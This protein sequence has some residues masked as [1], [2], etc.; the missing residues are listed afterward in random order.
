MTDGI[1]EIPFKQKK[2][3]SEAIMP[4]FV[5]CTGII[6]LFLVFKIF[7]IGNQVG[8]INTKSLPTLVQTLDGRAIKVTPE[9]ADYR[10]PEL[11]SQALREWL[12]LTFNWSSRPNKEGTVEPGVNFNGY[13][14]PKNAWEA[15][16][17][18]DESLRS[19]FLEILGKINASVPANSDVT[20]QIGSLSFPELQANETG[21]WKV[22]L[23]GT[24]L[25]AEASK[26]E[27]GIEFNKIVTLEAVP[28][29]L[30]PLP[31]GSSPI[32]T[33]VYRMRGK[34]IKI[35]SMEDYL[36]K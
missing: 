21:V 11:L 18:L 7:S 16:F 36:A 5:L 27:R 34:G 1:Q 19:S 32:Q 24:L 10:E 30:Y 3:N 2:I 14:V 17:L 20:F 35:A 31:S 29:P 15:S 6:Q 22:K 33:A 25:I 13:S 28:P 4:L 12:G 23:V 26:P 9:N 8:Q